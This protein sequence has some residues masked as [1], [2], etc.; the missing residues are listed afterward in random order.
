[1]TSFQAAEVTATTG[2]DGGFDYTF[3]AAIDHVIASAT[4]PQSGTPTLMAVNAAQNG[5][6]KV[7]VRCFNP[8]GSAIVDQQV[9]VTLLGIT[10]S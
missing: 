2:S 1:M 6:A 3:G 5:T 9:T 10:G 8:S 4:Q 7:H